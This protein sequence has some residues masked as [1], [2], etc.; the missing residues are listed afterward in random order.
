[1]NRCPHDVDVRACT[2]CT[3]RPATDDDDLPT[4]TA[5]YAGLCGACE[6]G[7][8]PGMAVTYVDDVLVHEGC[9]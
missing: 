1:M 3:P 9:A 7:V 8:R 4:F 6:D 5:R 2:I